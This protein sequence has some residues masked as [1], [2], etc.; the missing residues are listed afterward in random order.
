MAAGEFTKEEATQA[1][2][3]FAE[4]FKALSKKRSRTSSLSTQMTYSCSS[5]RRRSEPLRSD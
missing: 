5:M 2:E 1:E 3:D 4:V